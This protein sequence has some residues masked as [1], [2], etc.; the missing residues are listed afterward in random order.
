LKRYKEVTKAHYDVLHPPHKHQPS[1]KKR[2]KNKHSILFRL[3]ISNNQKTFP[4]TDIYLPL[5][6]INYLV[7][8]V[9]SDEIRGLITL[10]LDPDH[11]LHGGVLRRQRQDPTLRGP[12]VERHLW[13]HHDGRPGWNHASGVNLL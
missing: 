11:R 3:T 13:T 4:N 12:G 8:V 2:D 10:A 7:Y 1:M 6:H 9:V 5:K